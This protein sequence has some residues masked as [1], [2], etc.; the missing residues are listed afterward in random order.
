[1][2]GSEFRGS[3]AAQRPFEQ[4]FVRE[5]VVE[6]AEYGHEPFRESEARVRPLTGAVRQVDVIRIE[7]EIV[8][9]GAREASIRA[10]E[11]FPA[12]ER[13]NLVPV[14]E[15]VLVG[16]RGGRR[17]LLAVAGCLVVFV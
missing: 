10:L 3:V 17:P 16:Q 9:R 7:G 8:L 11:Y 13:S 4:I 1:A 15:G 6:T 5:A 12:E 14:G 2:V